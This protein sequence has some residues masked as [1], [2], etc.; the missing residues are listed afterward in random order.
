MIYVFVIYRAKQRQS[1]KHTS[2]GIMGKP[3]H[4]QESS[5]RRLWEE[6]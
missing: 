4:V 5:A 1:S 3:D 6:S 2:C